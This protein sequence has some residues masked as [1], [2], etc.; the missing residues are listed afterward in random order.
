MAASSNG[1]KSSYLLTFQY[2]SELLTL[3]MMRDIGFSADEIVTTRDKTVQYAY[4]HLKKK[5]RGE[6]LS[7]ALHA[8]ESRNVKKSEVF[9]YGSVDSNTPSEMEHIEDH[10]GFMTLVK[11]E[12]EDVDNFKRLHAIGY[13]D[14]NCGYNLLK[15]KLLSKRAPGP[16]AD[17]GGAGGGDGGYGGGASND[18]EHTR[19]SGLDREKSKRQRTDGMSDGGPD[20]VSSGSLEAM[21]EVERAET[22]EKIQ[23]LRRE[24]EALGAKYRLK[25]VD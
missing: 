16:S 6:E 9:G 18:D 2:N 11:N 23:E 14:E 21:M 15:K 8:L 13:R 19:P 24:L 1:G 12:T 25:V 4:V 22:D 10:P 20:F 17:G 3:E 7:R 5:A